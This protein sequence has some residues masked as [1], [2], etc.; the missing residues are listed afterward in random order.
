MTAAK[1]W[2]RGGKGQVAGKSEPKKVLDR[3]LAVDTLIEAVPTPVVGPPRRLPLD[4]S[5]RL[6]ATLHARGSDMSG[7]QNF[8][9][10]KSVTDEAANLYNSGDYRNALRGFQEL[11]KVNPRNRK[12]HETLAY[13]YLKLNDLKNAEREF[14]IVMQL[15]A[16]GEGAAMPIRS[17]EQ[18]I[19]DIG[20]PAKIEAEY[21]KVMTTGVSANEMVRSRAPIQLGMLYMARGQYKKAEEILIGFKNK[22]EGAVALSS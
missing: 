7:I 12:L 11:V 13:I 20:E 14:Q 18:I 5:R 2:H 6:I 4:R 10:Y 22:F 8:D 16:S 21:K 3:R 17:F 15:A 1:S 19:K 9:K